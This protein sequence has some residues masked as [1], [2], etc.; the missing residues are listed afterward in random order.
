MALKNLADDFPLHTNPFAVNN[1]KSGHASFLTDPNVFPYDLS[2]LSRRKLVQV[3]S[4]VDWKLDRVVIHRNDLS[5][6]PDIL[7]DKTS[8]DVIF[9]V[10]DNFL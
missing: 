1:A 10:D 2:G 7:W 3:K 4:A 6:G 9:A 8:I 5:V